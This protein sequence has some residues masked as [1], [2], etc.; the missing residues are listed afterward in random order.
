MDTHNDFHYFLEKPASSVVDVHFFVE[1]QKFFQQ[2]QQISRSQD[3][4]SKAS[5]SKK[6]RAF[7]A[8]FLVYWS[9]FEG[10]LLKKFF[11]Y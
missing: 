2:Q 6:D 10:L 4:V 3:R 8:F 9:F 5:R 11:V 1:F 7:L